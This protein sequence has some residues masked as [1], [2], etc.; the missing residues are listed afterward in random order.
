M[1]LTRMESSITATRRAF[2]SAAA[3]AGVAT[4][5]FG[6]P[7]R[8]AN[9]SSSSHGVVDLSEFGFVG[10]AD[11]DLGKGTDDT[12]AWRA[13]ISAAAERHAGTILV[14]WGRTGVSLVTDAIVDGVMPS[15]LRFIAAGPATVN[16][17]YGATLLYTG[18]EICWRITHPGRNS[19]EGGWMFSGLGFRTSDGR[20]TMFDFNDATTHGIVRDVDPRKYSALENIRFERCYFQGAGAGRNQTGDAIRGAKLFQLTIDDSCVIRDFRRAVWLHGCDNCSIAARIFLCARGVMV[21]ASGTFGNDN[22]IASRF[23]GGS[24][25]ANSEECY[26]LWDDANSTAIHEP[27]LEELSNRTAV[28][29]VYLN[30]YETLLLRPHF[31]GRPVFRLG[32]KAR[33]IVFLQPSITSYDGASPPIIDEPA[34]W[35][36]GYQQTDYRVSIIGANANV[37]AMFGTHPRLCYHATNRIGG[38]DRKRWAPLPATPSGG[39]GISL[40]ALNFWARCAGSAASGGVGGLVQD[41][42]ANGGWAIDLDRSIVQ[43]GLA[44]QLLVGR[45]LMPGDRLR[46]KARYRSAAS[47]GWFS[48]VS[49]NGAFVTN[50]PFPTSGAEWRTI[51]HVVQLDDWHPGDVLEHAIYQ[52]H[53][54]DGDMR[55]DFINYS[56]VP[57]P[58]A[59]PTGGAVIDEEARRAIAAVIAQISGP[60]G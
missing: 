16:G 3:A 4:P 7:A 43:G 52:G 22:L 9:A 20:A 24:P 19:S 57:P 12:S 58:P 56:A 25:A 21:E 60:A 13:A 23:V 15:G 17:R 29:L 44:A 42:A 10:D 45:D 46:L 50:V 11:A 36:F 34:S 47:E 35:D 59:L 39:H 40:T 32:P 37:Q 31:A 54:P 55:I 14:P 5:A 26:F 53:A 28:A 33:E 18:A 51:E 2:L 41:R 49:R 6:G 30:G 1:L 38:Y 8:S 48:V 27:Y